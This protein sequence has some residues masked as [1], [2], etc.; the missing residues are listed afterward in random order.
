MKIDEVQVK[1]D[2]LENQLRKVDIYDKDLYEN[3][4]RERNLGRLILDITERAKELEKFPRMNRHCVEWYD[5]YSAK[6]QDLK[7]KFDD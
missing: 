1:N 4:M 7:K 3:A 2:E 5:K 6:H